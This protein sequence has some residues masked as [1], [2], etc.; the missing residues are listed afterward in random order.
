MKRLNNLRGN[1]IL[2]HSLTTMKKI[3][4]DN[5]NNFLL[6][7]NNNINNNLNDNLKQ[8]SKKKKGEL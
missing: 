5:K 1:K 6:N 2:Y 7:N 3:A 4:I 8:L